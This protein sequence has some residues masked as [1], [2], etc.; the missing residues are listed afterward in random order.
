MRDV[1][2]HPIDNAAREGVYMMGGLA[3]G[4]LFG[5]LQNWLPNKLPAPITM[6][7]A[8]VSKIVVKITKCVLQRNSLVQNFHDVFLILDFDYLFLNYVCPLARVQAM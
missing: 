1:D 2:V 8:A 3:T 6:T 4:A 5:A 7:S